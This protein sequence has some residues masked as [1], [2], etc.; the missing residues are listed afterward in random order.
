MNQPYLSPQLAHGTVCVPNIE[1]ALALYRDVF[2][3]NVIHIGE[4]TQS[5]ATAWQ[6]PKLIGAKS[7]VLQP[8]SGAPVY[9]RLIE[10]PDPLGYKPGTHFGWAAIELSVKSADDMYARLQTLGTPI[11]AAPKHFL[12]PICFTQCRHVGRAGRPFI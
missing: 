11:I 8:P 7:V 5:E 2:E 6:T 9:L 10:Q 3:Q 1:A 4:V 12:L